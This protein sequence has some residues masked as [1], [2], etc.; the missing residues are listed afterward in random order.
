MKLEKFKMGLAHRADRH[1]MCGIH[2][3]HAGPVGR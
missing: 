2:C 1:C 3:N